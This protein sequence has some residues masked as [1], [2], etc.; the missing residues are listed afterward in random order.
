MT[1]RP[2]PCPKAD[3]RV[4][5]PPSREKYEAILDAAKRLLIAKGFAE[6]SMERIAR[7][8]AVSKA[9]L[10]KWFR[11]RNELYG[12][13]VRR[14]AERILNRFHGH[15]E[16][17]TG[18]DLRDELRNFG[19]SLLTYLTREESIHFSNL[20][21][22]ECGRS[23]ELAKHFFRA[24]PK[25]MHDELKVIL[26][27]HLGADNEPEIDVNTAASDLIALWRGF[28]EIAE[29][30]GWKPPPDKKQI[31]ERVYRGVRLFGELY[32][33]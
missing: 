22:A 12:A 32:S 17:E 1:E 23:P 29:R 31:E 26:V 24:G 9:T 33:I 28:D 8:A 30:F 16:R 27:R 10:Y 7:N 19:T 13:V 2:P 21:A 15:A 6:A 25:R 14:E 3:A 18:S 11:N 20:I 5:R 4:G